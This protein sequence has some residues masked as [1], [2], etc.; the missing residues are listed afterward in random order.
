MLSTCSLQN[1]PPEALE[2]PHLS[3]LRH[4]C[5][6]AVA[7][8]IDVDANDERATQALNMSWSA[9]AP[10]PA[11]CTDFHRDALCQFCMQVAKP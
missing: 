7:E 2:F 11:Q 8:P 10:P 6:Q 4:I 5:C 1:Q 3:C 9:S